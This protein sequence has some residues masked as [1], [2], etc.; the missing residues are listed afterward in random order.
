MDCGVVYHLYIKLP[1]KQINWNINV[2]AAYARNDASSNAAA[3]HWKR[4][5]HN[6][7]LRWLDLEKKHEAV[8]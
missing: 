5:V 7:I 3:A 2:T 6:C 4:R 1:L 8:M